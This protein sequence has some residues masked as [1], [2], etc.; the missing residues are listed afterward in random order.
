[1][2]NLENYVLNDWN[3]GGLGYLL[4][5]HFGS[6]GV[7]TT[8]I[9]NK[10]GHIVYLRHPGYI[11]I[12]NVINYLIEEKEE[13]FLYFARQNALGGTH[14][15]SS[16]QNN[17]EL[18]S[19]KK[20]RQILLNFI[21]TLKQLD[22]SADYENFFYETYVYIPTENNQ[23]NRIVEDLSITFNLK[24]QEYNNFQDLLNECYSLVPRE[25]FY[26]NLNKIN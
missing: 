3:N 20:V 13:K 2:T 19:Y 23:I 18:S 15:Y 11:N 25:N 12:E 5:N 21:Q 24:E 14:L 10:F 7:P 22:Y 8:I 16:G 1:L 6:S 26:V 9:V 17:F 4:K